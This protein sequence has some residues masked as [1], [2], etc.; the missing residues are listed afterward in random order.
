LEQQNL[1]A[2]EKIVKHIKEILACLSTCPTTKNFLENIHQILS[3]VACVDNFYVVLKEPDNTISFPY[4]VDTIDPFTEEQ[5]NQL[6]LEDLHATLTYYALQ[7]NR[8]CNFSYDDIIALQ[9]QKK[10]SMLGT[11]PKQ[12]V[13]YPLVHVEHAMGAFILQSYRSETEYSDEIM[14]L[15]SMISH[16]IA[17]ALNAFKNEQALANAHSELTKHKNKLDILVSEKTSE[18]IYEK[19]QLEREVQCRKSAQAKLEKSVQ[20]LNSEVEQNKFL[21][22]KLEYETTHDNLTGLAN[23]KAL[24][25]ALNKVVAKSSRQHSPVYCLY[26]DLDGFKAINDSLGHRAGDAIL[27]EISNRLSNEMRNYDLVSRMGGDEFVIL[28]D[29]VTCEHEVQTIA[30]RLIKSIER[31]ISLNQNTVHLSVIIGVAFSRVPEQIKENLMG[32][33]DSAMYQAKHKGAGNIIW[34][35][36]KEK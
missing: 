12:W 31:P 22:A 24:Y 21:R 2:S 11:I 5:L 18:L 35:N 9:A 20:E 33:A 1:T 15:L 6:K 23:R 16:V 10:V 4:F 32:F 26:L 8:P 13:C 30:E 36:D 25:S 14:E 7:S 34:F 28:L 17:A 29:G 3:T 27:V 19:Q